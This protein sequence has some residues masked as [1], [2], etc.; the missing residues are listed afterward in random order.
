MGRTDE[1]RIASNKRETGIIQLSSLTLENGST[2]EHVQV[3]YE[4]CGPKDAP[5]LLICHALTGNQ[6]TVGS[7]QEPGWWSSI[8]GEGR[9]IDTNY[10]Q[11]FTFNVL[12]G[13]HGSTGPTSLSPQNEYYRM[14]FPEIT[15]RDM[16]HTQKAALD[17]LRFTEIE[18]IIGGSLGGMQAMEWGLLY[19]DMMNKIIIMASTPSLSPYAIAFNHI[20]IEAIKKDPNWEEGD[21]QA[22]TDV[23]G[24]NIARMLGMVTYRTPSLF[25]ERFGRLRTNHDGVFD[26]EVS[27]YLSYHGEKIAK[28]FDANSYLYLL[29]AMNSHNIG[30]ERGGWE[31][32]A[33]QYKAQV[34]TVGFTDDLLYPPEEIEAFT[35]HVPHG[36]HERIHTEYG[37]DGF[38]VESEQ[39]GPKMAS[40]LG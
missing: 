40:F 17:K 11:T 25:D 8:V 37:H 12:G 27:H 14:R 24:F 33:G 31:R 26:Y 6:N 15:V 22:A 34:F 39:I 19:P 32:A 29:H 7:S 35:F 20:G 38:L 23:S 5:V 28:R 3:A 9:Y 21:Y 36:K 13:C 30:R 2:L 16:V 18:A 1:K 4:R 10:W